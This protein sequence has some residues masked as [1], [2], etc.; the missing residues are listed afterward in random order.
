[1]PSRKPSKV[2]LQASTCS[3]KYTHQYSTYHDQGFHLVICKRAPLCVTQQR[4]HASTCLCY[5]R[6]DA[7]PSLFCKSHCYSCRFL[8]QWLPDPQLSALR[9]P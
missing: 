4:H 2:R 8:S 9:V 1:M 5:H 3:T 6:L 7:L